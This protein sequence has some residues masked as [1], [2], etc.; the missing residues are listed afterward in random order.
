[1]IHEPLKA[2]EFGPLAHCFNTHYESNLANVIRRLDTAIFLYHY[3][4][5]EEDI[6]ELS[7][8]NSVQALQHIKNRLFEMYLKRMGWENV[9]WSSEM[10]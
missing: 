3:L 6:P 10:E 9:V 2:E 8:R 1:M 5:E 7:R 4:D